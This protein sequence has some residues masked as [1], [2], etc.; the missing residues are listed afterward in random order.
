MNGEI[1]LCPKNFQVW[2]A[3]LMGMVV[4]VIAIV[5]FD[6]VTN[7]RQSFTNRVTA[8]EIVEQRA[9]LPQSAY[10]QPDNMLVNGEVDDAAWLGI[11]VNDLDAAMA[12]QLGLEIDGGVIVSRVVAGSPAQQAGLLPG[13]IIFEFEHRD[14]EDVQ[15]LIKALSKADSDDRVKLALFR[16]GE[17]LVIYV[18]LDTL[19]AAGQVQTGV[20]AGAVAVS[21]SPDPLPADQWGVVLS[22]LT[23]PLRKLYQIPETENGVLVLVVIP[24]SVADRA[25]VM[26]GD[27]IR[28]VD[29][30]QIDHLSDF[31][32]AL[33]TAGSNVVFYIYR[34][35][36]ALLIN[37]SAALPTQALGLKVAQEG[38]GMNRP[39]YVP[40][41]DQTQ[42]G[43]PDDKTQS[44]TDP[45]T[46][47][48]TTQ[49][50]SYL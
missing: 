10:L 13:D 28:Q 39:V 24:G 36:T 46:D 27:L 16:D 41:Y 48:K 14:I 6:N 21:L 44:L 4:I 22:E 1:K 17:R 35:D 34:D 50:A 37:I 19:P 25:G 47:R 7:N 45:L 40:G 23:D 30:F 42:S 43:D 26:K 9:E 32:Q 18:A 2:V 5:A 20:K 33:Q 31:F 29:K 12:R 38:I 49:V 3:F 8:D 11:E 15:D